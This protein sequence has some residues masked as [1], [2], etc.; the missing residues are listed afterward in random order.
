MPPLPPDLARL[1]DDLQAAADRAM[2][3]RK[4]SRAAF[5]RGLI[6]VLVA[7][8]PAV[9]VMPE[10][11]AP[12]RPASLAARTPPGPLSKGELAADE[13]TVAL[14]IRASYRYPRSARQPRA[15]GRRSR[16]ASMPTRASREPRATR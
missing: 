6:V 3:A 8:T 7:V 10:A 11:L 16:P 2:A 4:A 1:G 5:R 15:A 12:V 13:A 9:L 14:G